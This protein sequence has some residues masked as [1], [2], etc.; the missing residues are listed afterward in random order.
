MKNFITTTAVALALASPAAAF[1][2][3]ER[4]ITIAGVDTSTLPVYIHGC[5]RFQYQP[6][7][8]RQ[9]A[10]LGEHCSVESYAD[11]GTEEEVVE[12]EIAIPRGV[13]DGAEFDKDNLTSMG[14]AVSD[15]QQVMRIRSATDG[16]PAELLRVGGPEVFQGTVDRGDTFVTVGTP[17]TYILT[18]GS[19]VV[20]KA[21]G[22]QTWNDVS[23]STRTVTVER[24][25][26]GVTGYMPGPRTSRCGFFGEVIQ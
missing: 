4:D 15:G 25:G 17:G 9:V 11:G 19:R 22:P 20:T 3:C 21:T 10:N 8:A 2:W 1:D 6:L 12:E 26:N 7:T 13:A 16:N 24:E 18:T 14:S 5:D 23:T